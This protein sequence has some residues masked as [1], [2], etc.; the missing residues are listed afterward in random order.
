M[1]SMETQTTIDLIG[2]ALLAIIGWFA[3]QIYQCVKDLERDV[4]DIEISLPTN[5][6]SKTDFAETM[7]DIKAMFQKIFDKLDDKADK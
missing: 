5:Y 3:R 6:V 1:D 4:R 2:G 7:R